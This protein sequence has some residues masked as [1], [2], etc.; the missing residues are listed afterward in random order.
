MR[1]EITTSCRKENTRFT[2]LNLLGWAMLCPYALELIR[3]GSTPLEKP[4]YPTAE[5]SK[6]WHETLKKIVKHAFGD[7]Y[8]ENS[9][10]SIQFELE[11]ELGI[12]LA[13][14]SICAKSKQDVFALVKTR[15]S[16]DKE[17]DQKC[18][19]LSLVK[20]KNSED[21]FALYIE[22]ASRINIAKPW[23]ALLRGIFLYYSLR[24]PVGIV[25]VSPEKI[26]YKVLTYEDQDA[27]LSC[28]HRSTERFEPRQNLCSLCELASFCPARAL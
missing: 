4:Y 20:T 13:D 18:H 3:H 28:L 24:L 10:L 27:I 16:K 9:L 12:Q 14:E 17:P 21:I 5:E 11:H 15:N 1:G 25:I 26:M 23:Q 8:I 7:R 2:R 19:M 6:D 22:L